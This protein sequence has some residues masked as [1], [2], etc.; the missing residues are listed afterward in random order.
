MDGSFSELVKKDRSI[1]RFRESEEISTQTLRGLVELARVS[2]SAGNL[3]PLRFYLSNTP[4]KNAEIFPALGWAG[5]LKD[6]PGPARGERPAA[7]IIILRDETVKVRAGY[8]EG[9]AAQSIMLGAAEKGFGGC[10]IGSIDTAKLRS[11]LAIPD[12][13]AIQLVLALG[14]PAEKSV[15]EPMADG[16]SVKY[17]RDEDGLHHVPKR[18]LDELIISR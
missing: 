7:Y 13:L 1:R 6:W 8:D 2:A 3:Q 15:L 18:S 4:E 5:Y 16:G 14:R 11:V 9:I 12:G 10:M 17:W